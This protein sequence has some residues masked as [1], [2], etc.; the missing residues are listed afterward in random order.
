[1]F[2]AMQLQPHGREAL[3]VLYRSAEAYLEM[4]ERATFSKDGA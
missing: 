4:W 3:G 1:M 2:R